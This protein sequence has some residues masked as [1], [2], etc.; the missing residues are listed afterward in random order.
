MNRRKSSNIIVKVVA[1][2]LVVAILA[3]GIAIIF[4]FTNGFNEDFK[5]FYLE[6]EGKSIVQSKSEMQF[7][8]G[9]EARFGVKYTFDVG[10]EVR[11]YSVK[12]S[13]NDEEG[14]TYTVGD[15]P[16]TWRAASETADLSKVFGLKKEAS[17]FTLTFPA[18][19]TVK[20]VLESVFAGGEITVP[21]EAAVSLKPLYRLEVSSYNGEITYTVN[22]SVVVPRVSVELDRDHI[23][24]GTEE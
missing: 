23:I 20:T 22:F 16:L 14:F 10:D 4:H 6:Y 13:P 1:V 3:A 19:M 7:T 2:I 11:D 9:S 8:A 15:R 24:F 17:S 21:D 12:I 5:T 18:E